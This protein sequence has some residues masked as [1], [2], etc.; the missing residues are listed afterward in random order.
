MWNVTDRMVHILAASSL[1]HAVKSVQYSEKKELLTKITTVLGLSF[2]P[3]TKNWLK[4]ALLVKDRLSTKT[5]IV[6]WHDLINN[7]IS[8]H[9]LNN[10]RPSSVQELANYLTTNNNKFKALVYCQRTG[11]PDIFKELLST[12]ILVLRVTEHLISERKEKTMLGDYRVLHQET[13]REIKSLD[14]VLRQQRNLKALLKKEKGRTSE[15]DR[16]RREQR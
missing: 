6:V 14:I 10:Y 13:A 9:K 7:S 12:G 15:N 11:T 3:N 5:D 1:H 4:Y 8:S 2:N 16:G